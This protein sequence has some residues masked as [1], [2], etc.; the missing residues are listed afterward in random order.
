MSNKIRYNYMIKYPKENNE[1]IDTVLGVCEFEEG[2]DYSVNVTNIVS[3]CALDDRGKNFWSNELTG[4]DLVSF[5]DYVES[6]QFLRD[7]EEEILKDIH[8]FS[9][10]G[11]LSERK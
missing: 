3:C 6:K 11:C 9:E 8:P 7:I 10:G 4:N 2:F 5:V 1:K